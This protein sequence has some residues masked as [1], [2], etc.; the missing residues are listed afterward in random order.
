MLICASSH[1]V[2]SPKWS[3]RNVLPAHDR[4]NRKKVLAQWTLDVNLAHLVAIGPLLDHDATV[5]DELRIPGVGAVFGLHSLGNEFGAQVRQQDLAVAN[6]NGRPL[7]LAFEYGNPGLAASGSVV[8]G[9]NHDGSIQ[10]HL[11][12]RHDKVQKADGARSDHGLRQF[13]G[14]RDLLFNQPLL[15]GPEGGRHQSCRISTVTDL[16]FHRLGVRRSPNRFFPAHHESLR[17]VGKRSDLVH[18]QNGFR[19]TIGLV[20]VGDHRG[21]ISRRL[22]SSQNDHLPGLEGSD[23]LPRGARIDSALERDVINFRNDFDAPVHGADLGGRPAVSSPYDSVPLRQIDGFHSTLVH[24][25]VFIVFVASVSVQS[26]IVLAA[27]LAS[28]L[29]Q[30]VA[31]VGGGSHARCSRGRVAEATLVDFVLLGTKLGGIHPR[32]NVPELFLLNGNPVVVLQDV[33]GV[34]V[35][36]FTDPKPGGQVLLTDPNRV[37]PQLKG[38]VEGLAK[39]EKEGG[40]EARFFLAKKGQVGR[41]GGGRRS[42]GGVGLSAGGSRFGGRGGA[43]RGPTRGAVLPESKPSLGQFDLP[44]HGLLFFLLAPFQSGGLF[45]FQKGRQLVSDQGSPARN[46]DVNLHHVVHFSVLRLGQ[47]PVLEQLVGNGEGRGLALGQGSAHHA[48]LDVVRPVIVRLVVGG[49]RR[50]RRRDL[51]RTGSLGCS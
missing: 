41:L 8:L 22:A 51:A 12:S 26:E 47:C 2:V 37:L 4:S 38:Q 21:R 36:G 5:Y 24:V 20:I 32:D 3:Q 30:L 28:A 50:R 29:G 27:T 35:Q 9:G 33:L 7:A 1:P 18:Q 17:S 13:D 31:V 45:P 44:Q 16:Q 23:R 15:L 25:L 49:G 39:L 42:P 48:V 46:Q 14:I 34:V 10:G 11:L 19:R 6:V 40:I 43:S